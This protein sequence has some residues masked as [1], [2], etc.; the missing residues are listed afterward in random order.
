M[1]ENEI[2]HAIIGAAI[3]VHRGLGPGLVEKIYEE[4]LC[5]E[6]SLLGL[7]FE[8]Q[9]PVPICYR[10]VK[11]AVPLV[12]DLIVENKVIVDLKVRKKI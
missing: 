3:R 9:K 6:L 1:H 5:Y 7:R 2:S 11:L 12:L 10:S 4:A 8:R